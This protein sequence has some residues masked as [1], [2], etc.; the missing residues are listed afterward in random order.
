MSNSYNELTTYREG[1][2]L[3]LAAI[4]LEE[5][6]KEMLQVLLRSSFPVFS[7]SKTSFEQDLDAGYRLIE[8]GLSAFADKSEEETKELLED[9]AADYAKTFLAAGDATGKAAFPYESIYT[10]TDSTFGGSLQQNL[11]AI[12]AAKGLSMSE[13]MFRVMEDHIG[14]ELE[15]M[16]MLLN[17]GAPVNEQK[18]FFEDH[19]INW[20]LS[21]TT[22]VYKYSERDFYKGIARI[23]TG[24]LEAE[25]QLFQE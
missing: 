2:Y 9:L 25:Q 8:S 12:Y 19:L 14:L 4:Y 24:F 20:A 22:D 10:G 18:A 6:D 5:V 11:A 13:E 23:T 16:A 15:F 1:M 7:D 3:F 21:F 17:E